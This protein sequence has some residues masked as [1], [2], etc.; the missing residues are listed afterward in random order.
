[1]Q[2]PPANANQETIA[3]LTTLHLLYQESCRFRSTIVSKADGIFSSAEE[4]SRLCNL[5]DENSFS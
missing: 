5:E 1:M 4:E 2:N 3:A